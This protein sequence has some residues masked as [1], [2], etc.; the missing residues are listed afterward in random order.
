MVYP[1][2]EKPGELRYITFETTTGWVGI[3]GSRRG[4]VRTTLPQSSAEEARRLLGEPVR[5]AEPTDHGFDSLIAC[6]RSYFEGNKIDFPERLDP[7]DATPFQLR[8]WEIAR[9]IPYGATRSYR[10]LAERLGNPK[11]AR[12]VGGALA[13]NPLPII[14]PC[15]R[16]VGKNGDL[17]GFSAGIEVKRRLLEL[18]GIKL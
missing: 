11:A 10:W 7:G 18:E 16:V 17:G 6:F 2:I 4:L 15:H 1:Q 9:L 14:I 12:A 8:V 13:Q 5:Y 3:L